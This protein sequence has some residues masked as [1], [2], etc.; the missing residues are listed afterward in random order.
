VGIVVGATVQCGLDVTVELDSGVEGAV[1]VGTCRVE[2]Y[3][4]GLGVPA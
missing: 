1:E 3:R 4:Q 2:L